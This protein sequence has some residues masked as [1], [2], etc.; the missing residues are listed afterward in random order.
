M[1]WVPGTLG[2]D[3]S[4]RAGWL[5]DPYQLTEDGLG[6]PDPNYKR[7]TENVKTERTKGKTHTHNRRII[8]F[9][10]QDQPG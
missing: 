4:R 8:T 10:L 9:R 3:P 7:H 5:M 6:N 2:E 1:D